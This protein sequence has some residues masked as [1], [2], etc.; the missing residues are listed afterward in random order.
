MHTQDDDLQ[1]EPLDL[2]FMN[3]KKDKSTNKSKYIPNSLSDRKNAQAS[4]LNSSF[5]H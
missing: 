1:L 5:S 3:F 4:P 2:D